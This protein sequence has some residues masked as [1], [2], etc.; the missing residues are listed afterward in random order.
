MEPLGLIPHAI[1]SRVKLL[2]PGFTPLGYYYTHFLTLQEGNTLH[3]T[4]ALLVPSVSSPPLPLEDTRLSTVIHHTRL[5]MVLSAGQ[6]A[7]A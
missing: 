7:A 4:P 3:I 6:S 2:T 5:L 1:T